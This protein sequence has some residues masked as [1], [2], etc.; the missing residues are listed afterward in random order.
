MA[1]RTNSLG[2]PIGFAVENWRAPPLPTRSKILEGRTCRLEPL[3]A[4]RHALDLFEANGRDKDGGMWTYMGVGPFATSEAYIAWAKDA[5]A[6][7]D[8]FFYAIVDKATGKAVGVASYL[9]IDPPNGVIEVGHI[10]Y[11]PLLQKTV[12]ATEAMYLMMRNAFE[13]GY[14]RYEWKCDCLNEPSRKAAARLGFSYEGRFRQAIMY[15]GRN[16]DTDWFSIIDKEWPA[17]R[18]GFETWLAPANF[19]AQGR[20]KAPLAVRRA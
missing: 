16:R 13:L 19:D 15:K 1:V 7:T 10:A 6:K 12:A 14:R 11:S 18:A 3:D 4:E 17:I 9:R 8:P 5:A 2:Q 20:Q